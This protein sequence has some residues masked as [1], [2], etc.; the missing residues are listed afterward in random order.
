MNSDEIWLLQLWSGAIGSFVAAVLGGLVALVVVRLTNSQQRRLAAEARERAAIAD[1][2][3]ATGAMLKK[4]WDGP[5]RVQ[6]LLLVAE[7]ASI[8]WSMETEYKALGSEVLT[9][10]YFIG[11]LALEAWEGLQATGKADEKAFDAMTEA[12]TVLYTFATYW[13]YMPDK[14]RVQGIENLAA[15]RTRVERDA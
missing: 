11:Q 4:Y 12:W 3:A 9:W 7:A 8:R 1:L 13:L 14:A 10:P 6:D 2:L 5:D 15:G